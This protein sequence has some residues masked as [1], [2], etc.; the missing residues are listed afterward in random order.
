MNPPASSTRREIYELAGD[1]GAKKLKRL[2]P[3]NDRCFSLDSRSAVIFHTIIFVRFI[4]MSISLSKSLLK[5]SARSSNAKALQLYIDE[6]KCCMHVYMYVITPLS[7]SFADPHESGF[8]SPFG[9]FD[10]FSPCLKH[11]YFTLFSL[12]LSLQL[13]VMCIIKAIHAQDIQI[14][15]IVFR[16][17]K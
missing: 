6:K 10:H 14:L 17:Y 11:V 1:R 12:S 15:R 2:I 5:K 4:R 7:P 3:L 9:S 8:K 16:C 13:D